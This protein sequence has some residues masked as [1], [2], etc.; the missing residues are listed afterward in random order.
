MKKLLTFSNSKEGFLAC[1]SA[2]VSENGGSKVHIITFPWDSYNAAIKKRSVPS[3][4]NICSYTT[5]PLFPAPPNASVIKFKSL[6]ITHYFQFLMCWGQKVT[7]KCIAHYRNTL[8]CCVDLLKYRCFKRNWTLK[9]EE[10]EFVSPV[11]HASC[12]RILFWS[13]AVIYQCCQLTL[14]YTVT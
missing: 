5:Q 10:Q 6:V 1:R 12:W 11:F 9:S 3:E 13:V 4:G 8:V 2:G 7:I 14:R